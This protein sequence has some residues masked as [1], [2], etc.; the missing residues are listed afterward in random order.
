MRSFAPRLATPSGDATS[1]ANTT[2]SKDDSSVDTLDIFLTVLVSR[3]QTSSEEGFINVCNIRMIIGR[4][5]R[6]GTPRLNFKIE[7]QL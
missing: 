2:S 4:G 7:P 3:H 1:S 5:T 6:R